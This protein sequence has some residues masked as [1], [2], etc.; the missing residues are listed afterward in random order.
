LLL[1]FLVLLLIAVAV[2]EAGTQALSGFI[3]DHLPFINAFAHLFLF[4]GGQLYN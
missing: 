1:A 3:E 2:T 4:I